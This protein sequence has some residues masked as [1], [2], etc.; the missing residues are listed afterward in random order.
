MRRC[1][2]LCSDVRPVTGVAYNV[3]ASRRRWAGGP[4]VP[5]VVRGARCEVEEKRRLL[6]VVG[7]LPLRLHRAFLTRENLELWGPAV[8]PR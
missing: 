5:C 3:S 1:S 7:L 8:D 4:G 2:S 6:Q